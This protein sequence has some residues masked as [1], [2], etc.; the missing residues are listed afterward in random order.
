MFG[1]MVPDLIRSGVRYHFELGL[2]DP[3]VRR[4]LL[5]AV[6]TILYVV[7]NI[8]AVSFRNA[9][10]FAVA[11]N[12]PSILMYAWNFYQLPYGVLAVALATAV[13]TELSLTAGKRDMVGFK[14]NFALGLRTTG[15]LI[16][17]SAAALVALAEPLVSLYRV[18]AFSEEA[19][20]PVTSALRFWGI[21]LVFYASMMFLL[22]TFYSLKDT[23]TPAL[24]NLALTGV[25]I[26]L[27]LVLTTGFAGWAG[28]GIDGIPI[29][30]GVFYALMLATLALLLRRKIGG[31][32]LAGVASTYARM[33]AAS[34]VGG[35]TAFAAAQALA[36]VAA[37]VA[38]ALLQV[39]VGGIV[40]FAVALGLGAAL[41]VPEVAALTSRV[42]TRLR[43]RRGK[44]RRGRR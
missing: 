33:A 31:Y 13:F 14:A 38:G 20:A 21:A 18:G 35:V 12:G 23:R 41:R 37:G 43:A 29:A 22:R 32:D 1:V 40:C 9:S 42:S 27:Y 30:D 15:V 44:E 16:L 6:P 7:T 3:D 24:A 2:S 39:L 4:M 25:Q 28:L 8:V 34:V 26:G 11:E 5:L 10:A 17:P 19:V 36:P